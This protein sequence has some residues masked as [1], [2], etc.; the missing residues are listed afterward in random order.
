VQALVRAA[1][2]FVAHDTMRLAGALAFYTALSLAP[3]VVILL[4]FLSYLHSGG[5]E[6]LIEQVQALIGPDGA[7]L[8]RGIIDSA[9]RDRTFSGIAGAL[10]MLVLAFSASGV[11]SELQGSLNTIWN[12]EAKPG[13]GVVG[14]LRKRLLTFA[15]LGALAFMLLVSLAASAGV[16]ALSRWWSEGPFV[17]AATLLVSWIVYGLMFGTVFKVLP[18]VR[19]AWRD[20]VTGGLITALLFAG[21]KSLIGLY[22]ARQGVGNA[23]GAAS[24][25]LVVLVWVYF[26]AVI[27]LWGAELTE[28]WAFVRGR[29]FEPNRFAVARSN[30][31][32]AVE[33]AE[34]KRHE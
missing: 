5:E 32:D 15:M 25:F 27:V 21:G 22:I 26:S 29:H 1:R 17:I 8:V 11:F 13:L 28:A 7:E 4:W 34:R 30:T 23:Y 31:S 19:V 6:F 10:S 18:D 3:L 14:W 9:S 20:V 16:A 12:V 33:N 24:S 2:A